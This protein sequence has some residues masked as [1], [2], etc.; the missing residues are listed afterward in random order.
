MLLEFAFRAGVFVLAGS[1]GAESSA[2][3]AEFCS[4]NL[5][6]NLSRVTG[7]PP[8]PFLV[9]ADT[10]RSCKSVELFLTPR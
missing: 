5:E 4:E 7:T 1:S 8:T 10:K 9:L 3:L 6:S 2:C